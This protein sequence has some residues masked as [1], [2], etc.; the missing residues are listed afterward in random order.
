MTV[1]IPDWLR[2]HDGELRPGA[3]G[4]ALLVYFR[5]EPQYVVQVVP[6]AGKFGCTVTQSING[7]RLEGNRTYDTKEEA[8]QGGLED[9]RQALGW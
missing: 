5:G 7:R 3:G 4:N 9:L 1:A 6:V 2:L 8:L